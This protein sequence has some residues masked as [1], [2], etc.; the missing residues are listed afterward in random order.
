MTVAELI[1]KLQRFSPDET[2]VISHP[3]H[4]ILNSWNT[5]TPVVF[6]EF[7]NDDRIVT[8]QYDNEQDAE[9]AVVLS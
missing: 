6:R 9:E 5:F 2:V 3:T 1:E 8:G 7:V 4:D